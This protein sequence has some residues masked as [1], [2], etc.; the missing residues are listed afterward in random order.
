MLEFEELR[1]RVRRV[2]T[3]RFAVIADGPVPDAAMVELSHRP[4]DLRRRFDQLLGEEFGAPS[5][6]QPMVERM[7]QLG[8]DVFEVLFQDLGPCLDQNLELARREGRGLRLRLDLPS[9]LSV[10]PFEALCAPADNPLQQLALSAEVSVVRSVD[11]Q[12]LG[13]KRLPA[14]TDDRERFSLLVV[15]A[16][17]D[18]PELPPVDP[19]LELEKLSDD[20]PGTAVELDLLG[21]SWDARPQ[22]ATRERLRAWLDRHASTPAAVLLIAHGAFEKGVGAVLLERDDGSADRVPAHI[23]ANELARARGL[24]LVVL[25]LCAGARGAPTE[26]FSGL[27]QAIVATGIPA[28]A[29]MQADV[30][31][32]AAARFSPMLFKD[33]CSN[34]TIDEAVAG[35][36]RAMAN[37]REG[38]TIEWATPA[39]FLHR[40]CYHGW[41]FKARQVVTQPERVDPLERGLRALE[42]VHSGHGDV[43]VGD[44]VE[45]ARHLRNQHRW[46]DVL[47]LVRHAGPDGGSLE[48]PEGEL[49]RLAQE[50]RSTLATGVIE[51]LC[52]ALAAE[53]D[54]GATLGLLDTRGRDL[55]GAVLACLRTEVEEAGRLDKLFR[56]AGAAAAA[57]DWEGAVAAYEE[58]L[59]RRP[60]GYR[61]SAARQDAARDELQLARAYGEA[62]AALD[63]GRWAEAAQAYASLVDRRP[64]G[65]R[66][67]VPKRHYAAGRRAEEQRDWPLAVSCHRAAG[68]LADAPAR[69]AHAEGMVAEAAGDWAAARRGFEAARAGGCGEE[70]SLLYATGRAAEADEDWEQA[71][72]AYGRLGGERDAPVRLLLARGRQAMRDQDWLAAE[73]AFRRLGDDPAAGGHLQVVHERLRDEAAAAVGAARWPEA[74]A[75]LER[76]P[77][78]QGDDPLQL[79]Y[80][81]GRAAEEQ[82]RWD[83]A[84]E[85]FRGPA[86]AGYRDS[87][88][89]LR[90]ATACASAAREDWESA[91]AQLKGLPAEHPDVRDRLRYALGRGAEVR[92][93]WAAVI[94]GFGRL[95][96]DY[97]D[98]DVGRRRGFARG[99]AAVMRQDWPVALEALSD[100]ADGD[101]DGQVGL[102][103]CRAEGRLAEAAGNW[104]AAAA[105]Y[106][107]G[108]EADTELARRWRYAS[109][110]VAEEAG[111][112]TTAGQLYQQLDPGDEDVADRAAYVRARLAELRQ[113]WQGAAE[114]YEQLDADFADTVRRQAAA[115]VRAA[116]ERDDWPGV[117]AAVER[118]DGGDPELGVLR[119]YATGRGAEPAGEWDLAAAA[120]AGCEGYRDAG[121]RRAYAA[122]RA[123]ERRGEWSNALAA[124]RQAPRD[125]ADSGARSH[126]LEC[127]L[128]L[129][130]WVD[131]LASAGLVEDRYA[132]RVGAAPYQELA[133]IGILPSSPAEELHDASF[134]MMER[135]AMTS[136]AQLALD[137]LRALPDRLRCDAGLYV[138]ADPEGLREAQQQLT[139]DQTSTEL[140]AELCRALP[141]D[142]PLLLLLGREREVAIGA[143]EQRL[144]GDVTDLEVVHSLAVAYAWLAREL[145]DSGAWEHADGAWQ[146]AIASWTVLLTDER[147]W[148]SW[149]QGRAACYGRDIGR[150][151][152]ARLRRELGRDLLDH[153]VGC[154][155]RHAAEGRPERAG[156][157]RR[158]SLAL[159]VELEAAQNVKDC[160][161]LPLPGTARGAIACG[162]IFVREAGLGRRLANWI[163]R[164]DAAADRDDPDMLAMPLDAVLGSSGAPDPLPGE[165][166]QRLRHSFSRLAHSAALLG[167][168]QPEQ[169][170]QA[171]PD[172]L[173]RRVFESGDDCQAA[174]ATRGSADHQRS[175]PVCPGFLRDDPAYLCLPRR[176]D[177]LVQDAA[178]LAVQAHLAIARAVPLTGPDAPGRMAAEWS[179]ACDVAR[180]AG[181]QVR[182]KQ[183]IVRQVVGLATMLSRTKGVQRGEHLDR[184]IELIEAALTVAGAVDRRKL[185]AAGSSLLGL[186]AMWNGYE[187]ES[188]D[189]TSDPDRSVADL[190]R[191]VQLDPSSHLALDNLAQGL[192]HRAREAPRED[193]ERSLFAIAEPLAI[194]HQALVDSAG[195][196]EL[197]KGLVR[198]LNVLHERVLDEL[199]I[200]ELL[201]RRIV[202]VESARDDDGDAAS[203]VPSLLDDGK[204]VD[205]TL[206]AIAGVRR[207][208]EDA[209]ARELLLDTLERWRRLDHEQDKEPG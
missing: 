56:E 113:D 73:E 20:L 80:V 90:Y 180:A 42:Q 194:L 15:V 54:P 155:D 67:A 149:K 97:H 161:G 108:A 57:E 147:H 163:A 167:Q 121:S 89:R 44:L 150:G 175:C 45:A 88:V 165:M 160:G 28:V 30:S 41:L 173:Q 123:L 84:I 125:L 126:R 195:D 114:A 116:A 5:G 77:P 1:V 190:R 185:L 8:R 76:L 98:G 70:G 17:P 71:V 95:P 130:P 83:D 96:D 112:W 139:V 203:R 170:L 120:Y 74:A 47:R 10:I 183:A 78:S 79:A 91:A 166:L 188:Y 81:R 37:T 146:Q 66:D 124:Y 115:R 58:L 82:G 122:A 141:K 4:E 103:R 7:R 31:D 169:A 49:L 65:Y 39:L 85:A 171:L 24:R 197:T 36:R 154:G 159:Q 101:H 107:R 2:G 87:E 33:V 156:T 181:T 25:N 94:R 29:A 196:R 168:Q 148:E 200:K 134:V 202:E 182:A 132:R 131:G 9:E 174:P 153:L 40:D 162:P 26:P 62:E 51:N 64:D 19:R 75:L 137:R 135:D 111:D 68:E 186:R 208:P 157:Y 102:L 127:L 60:R 92:G 142:A 206:E 109:G 177:L 158:L 193:R 11:G 61:E 205:A 117:L 143:W 22:R 136:T 93:D 129:L 140:L 199:S 128:E 172:L 72:A 118:L 50:A 191:A 38:T 144:V 133:G 86:D 43:L 110:R 105:A 119:A 179:A 104:A 12:P 99:A 13:P 53:G 3:D 27:A 46:N 106:Q 201:Q 32:P 23:L 48:S 209:S 138:L 164:L 207:A 151:D 6:P 100:L 55:P 192:T 176:S 189:L 187:S 184:A 18:D 34:R 35:G 14:P 21:W 52:Q 63:A 198:V 16:R 145:E 69:L 178:D 204:V 59:R 152:V